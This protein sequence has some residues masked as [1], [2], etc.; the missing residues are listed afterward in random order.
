MRYTLAYD[1]DC[2]PCASFRRAVGFLDP[3]RKMSY[4]PL[5]EA[6]QAGTLDAVPERK[7]RTS[8]HLISDDGT[9]ASG[10]DALPALVSQ[11]PGG[12]FTSRALLSSGLLRGLASF[13][14]GALSRLHDA[15]S[16]REVSRRPLRAAP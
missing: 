15:G 4:V 8:F 1:A 14:Y 12:A 7:R 10:A 9:A 11:L 16:C 2:G 13:S 6:E 3:A 5:A